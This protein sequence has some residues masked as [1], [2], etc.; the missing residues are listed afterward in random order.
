MK[1]PYFF[2]YLFVRAAKGL[3]LL[4]LLIGSGFCLLQYSQANT[5]ASAVA[6][7][8]SVSLQRSLARLKDAFSVTEHTVSSFNTDNQLTTPSVQEPRFPTVINSNADFVHVNDALSR[9]DQDRQQLKQSIVSRFESS[10][11]SIEEKLRAYAAG[12]GSLPLPT[13]AAVP[14]PVSVATPL[15]FLSQQQESLFSPKLDTDEINKRSAKLTR[16]KELLKVLETKAENPEN[17]AKIS[18]AVNQLTLLSKLLPE[19]FETSVA[20]PSQPT[21]TLSDEPGTEQSRTVSLSERTAAQLQQLRGEV[22]QILLTSWTLDDSFEQATEISAT[23]RDKCRV[24]TLAQKGIWL[25]AVSRILIGLLAAILGSFLMLVC[26]DVVQTLLTTVANTS[27]VADA[28]N[29]LRGSVAPSSERE[30]RQP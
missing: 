30:S 8:P 3:A 18:E 4:V 28:V 1:E 27:V 13:P 24:S 5:A 22:R 9:I 6:Y 23:A 11:K 15:P 26:S 10:V 17:R 7:Q 25:S 21:P 19:K 16:R 12:L 20:A 14:S 2:G 29:A